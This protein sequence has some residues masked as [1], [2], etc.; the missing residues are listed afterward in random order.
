MEPSTHTTPPD[1]NYFPERLDLLVGRI[2]PGPLRAGIERA[3][4]DLTRLLA[5]STLVDER[6]LEDCP[7]SEAL[8]LFTPFQEEAW[9]LLEFLREEAARAEGRNHALYDALDGVCYAIR[10]E[11]RRVFEDELM[12]LETLRNPSSVKV[13]VARANDLLRNCFQQTTVTLAQ[14]F[15]PSLDGPAIFDNYR[16]RLEQS[17]ALCKELWVLVQRIRRA[18]REQDCA[19]IVAFIEGLKKFRHTSMHYL[20]Y[21]DWQGFEAHVR[22]V[23]GTKDTGELVPVLAEFDDYL[24]ALLGHVRRRAVLLNHQ[25]DTK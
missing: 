13:Q 23:L 22:R 2:E 11:L 12:G 8:G 7:V 6:L 20:M 25:A 1:V 21:K 4:G 9:A 14:V 24:E 19:S 5:R 16:D 18:R 15:D 17:L 3:F 10:H